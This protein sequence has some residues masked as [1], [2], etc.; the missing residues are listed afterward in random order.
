MN[1]NLEKKMYISFKL[2]E[3]YSLKKI[4]DPEAKTK[5]LFFF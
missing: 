1:V 2:Q 5:L 4:D 3:N